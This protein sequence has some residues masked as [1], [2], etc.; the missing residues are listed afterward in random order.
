[1]K[2]GS[3]SNER[4]NGEVMELGIEERDWAR[5]CCP[6][7]IP[8]IKEPKHSITTTGRAGDNWTSYCFYRSWPFRLL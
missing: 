1:M 7:N 3:P 2:S 5:L 4:I 6:Q 8:G